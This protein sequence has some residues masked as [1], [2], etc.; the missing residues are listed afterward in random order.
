MAHELSCEI[1]VAILGRKE[2]PR[3]LNELKELVLQV[4]EVLQRLTEQCR[5]HTRS[6]TNKRIGS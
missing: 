6:G 4:H 2:E 5:E 1:A 3:N